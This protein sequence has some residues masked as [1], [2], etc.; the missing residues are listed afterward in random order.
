VM[1]HYV[2]NHMVAGT[3]A[4]GTYADRKIPF[5]SIA[6]DQQRGIETPRQT[7]YEPLDQVM[8]SIAR[9]CDIGWHVYLD[10]DNKKWVFDVIEGRDLTAG[11]TTNPPVIFSRNFDNVLSQEYK[12]SDV[13]Y[14]N[15]GYAAGL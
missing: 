7:R 13:S 15:V 9:W 3:Y 12:E 4:T 14:R 5:M 11:Q 2:N 1:K 10:F 6:P 8:E